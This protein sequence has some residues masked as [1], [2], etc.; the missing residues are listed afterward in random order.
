MNVVCEYK[1]RM[2]LSD[3]AMAVSFTARG[4]EKDKLR[5]IADKITKWQERGKEAV[6]LEITVKKYSPKRSIEANAYAWTLIG[7]LANKSKLD[8]NAIYKDYIVELGIKQT[9]Q[10]N[11]EAVKTLL[12]AWADRGLGWITEVLD[13]D[14]RGLTLVD[15]YYGSSSFNKKQMNDLTN[16]IVNDCKL[17]GIETRTPDQI[18]QMINLW[19]EK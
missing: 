4:E 9:V 2:L 1:E 5:Q 10:I 15:L 11:K 7:K 3:G 6:K 8:K 12:H 18:A 14:D 13:T 17:E 16:L 19:G